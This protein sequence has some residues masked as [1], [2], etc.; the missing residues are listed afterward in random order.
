M[1]HTPSLYTYEWICFSICVR[2]VQFSQNW[3]LHYMMMIWWFSCRNH[4]LT[5]NINF[6]GHNGIKLPQR[7]R[8]RNRRRVSKN[9]MKTIRLVLFAVIQSNRMIPFCI[10][11]VKMLCNRS[12]RL[13]L[14]LDRSRNICFRLFRIYFC[15]L[16]A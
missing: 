9:P 8:V 10:W 14:N 5:I 11:M 12:L 3:L 2:I 7:S 1:I 13:L 4:W 15:N 6:N 16:S